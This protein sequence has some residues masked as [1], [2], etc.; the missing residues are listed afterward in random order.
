MH[1]PVHRQEST[2][3]MIVHVLPYSEPWP[4][5]FSRDTCQICS[6]V[7]SWKNE[8][9]IDNERRKKLTATKKANKNHRKISAHTS[10]Q[11]ING[12]SVNFASQLFNFCTCLLSVRCCGGSSPRLCGA[13]QH[14]HTHLHQTYTGGTI[15]KYTSM[16]THSINQQITC[17][18][19]R[20]ADSLED[21]VF[22]KCL[23]VE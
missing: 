19:G 17:C 14:Q 15:Y 5:L 10:P 21:G 6:I 16:K 20:I 11:I 9:Y 12:W 8:Y 18:E 2:F 23:S 22:Q 7:P 3:T 13:G 1:S 4:G